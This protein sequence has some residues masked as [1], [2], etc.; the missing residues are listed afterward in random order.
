[1]VVVIVAAVADG[2]LM[3]NVEVVAEAGKADDA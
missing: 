1:M 2:A 3:G